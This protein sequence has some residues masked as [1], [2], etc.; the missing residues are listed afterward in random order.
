MSSDPISGKRMPGAH[1]FRLR[2][3]RDI[4]PNRYFAFLN[5]SCK[6]K[7]SLLHLQSRLQ[8]KKFQTKYLNKNIVT[9]QLLYTFGLE[10]TNISALSCSPLK[11][12]CDCLHSFSNQNNPNGKKR[13]PWCVC[14][15]V[16][17]GVGRHMPVK[18]A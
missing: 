2:E 4:S 11:I 16:G 15:C 1:F 12:I 7:F 6:S 14:V 13:N 17:G 10:K 3:G 18:V 9:V 5:F 8:N